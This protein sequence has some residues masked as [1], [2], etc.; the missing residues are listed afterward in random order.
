[1]SK[2][3][4]RPNFLLLTSYFMFYRHIKGLK[5]LVWVKC[6]CVA[7]GGGGVVVAH[8]LFYYLF[9]YSYLEELGVAV[10]QF[11]TQK[12]CHR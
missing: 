10:L 6:V 5:K 3:K 8:G 9:S 12:Q 7:G 2:Y 11:D 4:V 1:M